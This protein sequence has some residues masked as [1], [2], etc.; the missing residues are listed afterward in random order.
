MA[1]C[2]NLAERPVTSPLNDRSRVLFGGRT[3][4]T[5]RAGLV[6]AAGTVVACSVPNLPAWA[7][8]EPVVLTLAWTA[9]ALCLLLLGLRRSGGWLTSPWLAAGGVLLCLPLAW[10]PVWADRY[11][12]LS[13]AG[14]LLLCLMQLSGLGGRP[15]SEAVARRT[16]GLLVLAGLACVAAVCRQVWWPV[17]ATSWF[18][19]MG[20]G[21]P[22]GVFQQINNMASFLATAAVVAAHLWLTRRRG[23]WLVCMVLLTFALALCQS[24]VGWLGLLVTG[25][26]LAVAGWRASRLASVAAVLTLAAGYGAGLFALRFGGHALVDHEAS[27]AVRAALW[28][29]SAELGLAHP[30]TGAGAGSFAGV[31]TGGLRDLNITIPGGDW[32]THP[33]NELLYRWVEGGLTGVAGLLCLIVWGAGLT[34]RTLARARRHGG[35]GTPGQDAPGWLL[36]CLPV[37]LHTQTEYPL[38]QSSLH[39]MVLVLLA[40]TG[41]AR[42]ASPGVVWQPGRAGRWLTGCIT[43]PVALLLAWWVVTGVRVQGAAARATLTAGGVSAP[44]SAALKVNPWYAPDAVGYVRVQQDSRRWNADHNPARL[45]RIRAFMSGYAI[46]YPTRDNWLI[47]LSVLRAQHDD[48]AYAQALKDARR[49]VPSLSDF[50][51][52]H[53]ND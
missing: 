38:I 12:A 25:L 17:M 48:A 1:A 31:L 27:R 33:H 14:G 51:Q 34:C 30:L 16:G 21:R 42:S 41:A 20:D 13:Q 49:R 8:G 36:C 47:L 2:R 40:G 5:G 35:Y 26:A 44:L 45:V 7:G 24:T 11:G 18:P 3:D 29:A 9:A 6:L 50:Q 28:R 43:L 23:V 46:R 32:F 19:L 52:G 37:L 15:V 22:S 39:C 53:S 4:G 10:M